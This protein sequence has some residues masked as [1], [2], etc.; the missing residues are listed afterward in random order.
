MKRPPRPCCCRGRAE[1]HAI[2]LLL[3]RLA[4]ALAEPTSRTRPRV[5]REWP[6]ILKRATRCR[7]VR[8]CRCKNRVQPWVAHH[9][10]RVALTGEPGGLL[11]FT[12]CARL[13]S[14]LPMFHTPYGRYYGCAVCTEQ[15]R[16][17]PASAVRPSIRFDLGPSSM[18]PRH[19]MNTSTRRPPPNASDAPTYAVSTEA[20]IASTSQ[21]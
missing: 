17:T 16:P 6:S 18:A 9:F 15:A 13:T 20:A 5:Q 8:C 14:F 12:P 1:G 7:K 2:M 19:S 11:Y 21:P 4:V 10:L 3:L